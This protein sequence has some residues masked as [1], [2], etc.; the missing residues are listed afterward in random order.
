MTLTVDTRHDITLDAVLRVAWHGEHVV[1]SDA[2]VE[3]MV[4][5]RQRFMHLLDADPDIT[6]YGVTTG[7][8]QM[9][10]HKLS[11]EERRAQAARPPIAPAASW[12]DP[13]PDRVA[14]T[15][16]LARL[17]N[18]VEGHAA[19]SPPVAQAVAAMLAND[20]MPEVPA[21]GQG[22]AG[23]ILSLSHL[24]LDVAHQSELGEK[25][26]LSLVNGSPCASALVADVALTTERRLGIAAEI[27]SLS[28]DA[29]KAP[30]GHFD[31]A[32]ETQWNNVH[33]AWALRTIRSLV[34]DEGAGPRRPYQA[35]V[36]FR[37]L[38]RI[39]GQAHRAWTLARDIAAE[40]LAAVTDNP[41]Y[42]DADE[43]HPFGQFI[44]TGGYHN[45]Q[46]VM[47]MDAV[48]ASLANLCIIVERHSAKLLDGSVSLLPDHLVRS[49]DQDDLRRGYLGCLAMAATGYEEEARHEARA[50]LL[51]GS[52]S[53]GFGQNDVASPIFFAWTK[54]NRAARALDMALASLAPIALRAYRVT[55]RAPPK[56]LA[57]WQ[58]PIDAA[59]PGLDTSAPLGPRA[60]SLAEHIAVRIF[61]NASSPVPA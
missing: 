25:D 6:I 13:V 54:A 61:D 10:K 34:A 20:K 43:E 57:H 2:A 47:A 21:S 19:I 7:F 5:A 48:T 56:T 59:F 23:E 55:D 31:E 24:F 32:L 53:G 52:E 15:M 11:P 35:P 16:V 46:A 39:L 22:G 8:G 12:G 44:S 41:V 60:A 51:P 38:P 28:A 4:E 45:A 17:A 50:T 58:A 40:S 1:L 18:F 14:R 3:R 9:A 30:L 27:L 33:D 29:F 42:L 49:D 26:G 37:I 36:S